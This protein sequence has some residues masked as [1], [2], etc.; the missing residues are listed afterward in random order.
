MI[1]SYSAAELEVVD[2]ALE[3]MQL[4]DAVLLKA[5]KIRA[6][7]QNKPKCPSL[8]SERP[9]TSSS[10]TKSSQK[11]AKIYK[12]PTVMAQNYARRVNFSSKSCPKVTANTGQRKKSVS[13]TK[14]CTEHPPSTTKA[15]GGTGM[16]KTAKTLPPVGKEAKDIHKAAFYK[17]ESERE[18]DS[19]TKDTFDIKQNG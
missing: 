12:Q 6:P 10:S 8:P 19:D 16:L 5:E 7:P 9:K 17:S 13:Y 11:A 1:Y 14:K 3:E 4:L 18:V 15:I 2:K